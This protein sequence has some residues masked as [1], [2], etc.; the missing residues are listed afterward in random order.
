MANI[1]ESYVGGAAES[2]VGGAAAKKGTPTMSSKYVQ[3]FFCLMVVLRCPET[4][5]QMTAKKQEEWCMNLYYSIVDEFIG[6]DRSSGHCPVT[7]SL[8]KHVTESVFSLT[9]ENN[10]IR[11][12]LLRTK[13]DELITGV[14]VISF[15]ASASA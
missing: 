5:L 11:E 7:G 6:K 9:A 15:A 2:Y 3:K 13:G 12:R 14:G 8:F 10:G 1:E 4:S